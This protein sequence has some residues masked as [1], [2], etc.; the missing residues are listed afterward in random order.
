[1]NFEYKNKS[2]GGQCRKIRR[3]LSYR[4][5][6]NVKHSRHVDRSNLIVLTNSDFNELQPPVRHV[7]NES[8]LKIV[9]IN[10][11]SIRNKTHIINI[12]CGK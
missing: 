8:T 4:N 2:R 11:Q 12:C 5:D 9:L 3:I 10:A 1:M 7:S 6:T